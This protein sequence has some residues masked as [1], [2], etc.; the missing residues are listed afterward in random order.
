[1][2]LVLVWLFKD[3]NNAYMGWHYVQVEDYAA[4]M[5]WLPVSS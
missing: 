2:R 1:M 3:F 4:A 5:V